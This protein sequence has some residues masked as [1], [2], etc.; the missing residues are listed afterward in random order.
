MNYTIKRGDT[1]SALASRF[2]TSVSALAKANGI[3][4]VNL[5]Y[6]GEHLRVPGGSDSFGGSR[7]A[8]SSGGSS[9]TPGPSSGG[10]N[11]AFQIAQ[12]EMGKNAGSLKLEHSAVG[13][14]M[15]DWVPNTECCASFVSACLQAAG[16]I[17]HSQYSAGSLQLQHN[18]DNDPHFKRV[19]LANAK[20][21]DVVTFDTGSGNH[22]V[23]FAGYRNGKPLFLGSNNVNPDGS[24]KITEENMGYRILSIQ[25]YV[26]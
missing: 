6:A 16:Q 9:F 8:P 21:G 15:E 24:Q 23:M 19:S 20:P 11:R 25:H 7:P 13:N 10:S 2:H 18:L 14:A 5:I 1:L 3:R 22:T 4:N 17:N 12:S 26:G